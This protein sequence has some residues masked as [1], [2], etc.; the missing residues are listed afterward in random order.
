MAECFYK[1]KTTEPCTDP[2]LA[3]VVCLLLRACSG[4]I[5]PIL[6]FVCH[7]CND[8]KELITIHKIKKSYKKN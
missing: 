3:A 5:L 1:C 7:C 4:K 2:F 8:N 6:D